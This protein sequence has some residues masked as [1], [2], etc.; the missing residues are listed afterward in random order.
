MPMSA[1]SG[2]AGFAVAVAV[3]RQ[4]VHHIEVDDVRPVPQ[5]IRDG[6]ARVPHGLQE[7]VLFAAPHTAAG[8][9]RVDPLFAL[10]AAQPDGD[11]LDGA[12]VACHGVALEVGEHHIAVVVGKGRPHIV[13]LQPGAALHRQGHRA[14]FVLD[15]YR[16]DVGKAVLPGHLVMSLGGAAG[17]A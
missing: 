15:L 9:A 11:I 7:S 1:I 10:P 14:V 5:G 4:A 6:F 13:F 17:A 8:A 3:H 12:P 2:S 16:G